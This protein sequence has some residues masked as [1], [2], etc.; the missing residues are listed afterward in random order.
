MS[1]HYRQQSL[2]EFFWLD[3]F[4]KMLEFEWPGLEH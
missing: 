1:A 3:Q 4:A 2:E